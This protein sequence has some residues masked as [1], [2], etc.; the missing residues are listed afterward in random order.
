MHSTSLNNALFLCCLCVCVFFSS[1]VIV[2]LLVCHQPTAPTLQTSPATP[3]T[4]TTD[5]TPSLTGTTTGKD[6]QTPNSKTQTGTS[7][8]S[9]SMGT[10]PR[11]PPPDIS[12]TTTTPSRL[13]F[14]TTPPLP[15]P[16][17]TEYNPFNYT[18]MEPN[19]GQQLVCMFKIPLRSL[20]LSFYFGQIN[21][22][23]TNLFTGKFLVERIP[24]HERIKAEIEHI[25]SEDEC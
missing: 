9:E 6:G 20:S 14:R 19:S 12:A 16:T 17:T 7:N 15:Q 21:N 1:S 3:A 2:F 13:T 24:N 22:S 5:Q 25:R 4:D 8:S 23:K 11:P 10:Y 18:P